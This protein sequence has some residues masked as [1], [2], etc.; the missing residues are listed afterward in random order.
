M[1]ERISDEKMTLVEHLRQLGR[2][3]KI[4]LMW[5]AAGVA[6]AFFLREEILALLTAPLEPALG[7]H[8]KLHFSSPVEPFFTYMRLSF[9]AGLLFAMPAILYNLWAFVAPGLH[10]SER[11]FVLR[12]TLWAV[13]LFAAGVAFAYFIVFPY[14]FAFLLDFARLST[15]P[16]PYFV[17]LQ[18]ALRAL[19]GPSVQ[20]AIAGGLALEPTIMMDGY[21]TLI[22]NLMLVFGLVFEFPLALYYLAVSQLFSIRT[23]LHFFRYFVVIAFIVAAILTPPD[24]ATQVMMAVPMLFMYLASVGLAALVLRL[25][26][27]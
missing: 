21:L 16:S 7:A 26:K 24:V 3:I 22:M 15:A 8:P 4:S 14:G 13:L 19:Y 1:A 18:E 5:L 2:R 9:Q 23:L 20:L 25:R 27:P 10:R 12:I 17:H 11:R 6:F